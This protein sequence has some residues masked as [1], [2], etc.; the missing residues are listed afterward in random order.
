LSLKDD[1]RAFKS[2]DVNTLN[3]TTFRDS[4]DDRREFMSNGHASL[5][6]SD[7]EGNLGANI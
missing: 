6:E 2:E 7:R 3:A 5:I 1:K 4:D